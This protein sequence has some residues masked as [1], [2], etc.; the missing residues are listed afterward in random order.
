MTGLVIRIGEM[1][2]LLR[3][4][5]FFGPKTNLINL[6]SFPVKAKLNEKRSPFKLSAVSFLICEILIRADAGCRFKKQKNRAP[7]TVPD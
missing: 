3:C 6:L 5:L 4:Y 2:I 7:I 1:V